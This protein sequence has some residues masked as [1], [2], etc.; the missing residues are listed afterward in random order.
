MT[1]SCSAPFPYPNRGRRGVV[2]NSGLQDTIQC[3][4][5]PLSKV[6][7]KVHLLHSPSTSLPW[8]HLDAVNMSDLFIQTRLAKT[9]PQPHNMELDHILSFHKGYDAVPS[10]QGQQKHGGMTQTSV[11]IDDKHRNAALMQRCLWT[12]TMLG[13]C[14][15]LL[16]KCFTFSWK[17]LQ[18]RQR[19]S[20]GATVLAGTEF[21][22]NFYRAT[23]TWWA[24]LG[25]LP[26]KL[27]SALP[28][29][30]EKIRGKAHGLR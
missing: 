30:M 28:L 16:N 24:D 27:L 15:T 9:I 13:Q 12:C 22:L 1:V 20:H 11:S 29:S 6:T 4:S 3:T 26:T 17:R 7:S 21:N 19:N 23:V 2:P 10:I 18:G 25:Q 5:S 8:V 14:F